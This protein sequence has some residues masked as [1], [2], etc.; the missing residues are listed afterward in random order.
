L[1]FLVGGSTDRIWTSGSK[2]G[3][4]KYL[5]CPSGIAL[6]PSLDYYAPGGGI[7]PAAYLLTLGFSNKSGTL[8][9]KYVD[10]LQKQW[11][12]AMCEE[13]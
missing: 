1:T 11:A 5:W 12:M 8:K 7:D 4:S 6:L 9:M 3:S 2:W 10:E 13:P